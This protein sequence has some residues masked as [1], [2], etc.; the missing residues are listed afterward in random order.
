MQIDHSPHYRCGAQY[1]F[2]PHLPAG[3]PRAQRFKKEIRATV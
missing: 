3:E 2:L 1:A